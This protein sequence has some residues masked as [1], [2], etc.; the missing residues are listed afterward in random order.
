MK[1]LLLTVIALVN[2]KMAFSQKPNNKIAKGQFPSSSVFNQSSAPEFIKGKVVFINEQGNYEFDSGRLLNVETDNNTGEVHYRTQQLI[3]GFVVENA[4][5]LQHVLNN[6]VVTANGRWLKHYPAK[7]LSKPAIPVNAAL[8]NALQKCGASVYKW[9][10][11][12]E[13][14]LLKKELKNEGATYYPTAV[15]VYYSGEEDVDS[16]KLRLAY[17]FDIYA[18]TPLSRQYIFIDASDGKVL[19]TRNLLHRVNTPA[20]AITVFSGS[21]GIVTD[22]TDG[23][24]RLRETGRGQGIETYNLVTSDNYSAA[25][26]FLNPTTIWNNV[27]DKKDQYATD[28][29]W[30]T[31]KTWDYFYYKF[32]RNSIDNAGFAL[33]SYV[34]YST[35]FY[36][37][38]W[39]GL[40]MTYGDGNSINNYQPLTTLDV[41]GHEISHGVTQYT[42][43]LI[44]SGES[45]AINEGLS[46]IFG[47]A[48]ENYARPLKW[49]WIIGGDFA[50]FRNMSDPGAYLQPDTYKGR[51]WDPGEEV[52]TN[53]GVL[54][55]WFY[56]LSAG[57]SGNNDIFCNYKVQG[58]GIEKAA[59]IAFKTNTQYL[60]PT[61]KYEDAAK[62]SLMAAADLYGE[63]SN[64]VAQTA[65]A[66]AAVGINIQATIPLVVAAAPVICAGNSTRLSIIGGKLNGAAYW[67]WYTGKCGGN[68]AGTGTSTDVMPDS[69]TTYYVRGEGGC[70][71]FTDCAPVTVTVNRVTPKPVIAVSGPTSF[72]QGQSVILSGAPGFTSYLW[73]DGS[74]SV[75]LMVNKSGSYRLKVSSA[76]GCESQLSDPVIVN[77]SASATVPVITV[78]GSTTTCLSG[79]VMLTAS[80]AFSYLWSTGEKLQSISVSKPGSYSVTTTTETGCSATSLPGV[81]QFTDNQAPVP[82]IANLP[83]ITADCS[84]TITNIPVAM[85]SCAGLIHATTNDP[86]SYNTLGYHT[87]KW[88]YNDGNGNSSFQQQQVLI[89]D[90][91]PPVIVCPAFPGGCSATSGIYPVPVA[92]ATDNCGVDMSGFSFTVSGAT[93]RSGSGADASGFF[94]IGVNTLTYT[95]KD[96]NGNTGSCSTTILISAGINA[97]IPDV[98]AVSPGGQANTLYIGY[99]A[100]SFQLAASATGGSGIYTYNWSTGE[101]TKS[102][103]VTPTTPGTYSYSVTVTDS[104]GCFVVIS[105]TIHVVD[106]RCGNKND[107]VAICMVPPGNTEKSKTNCVSPNGAAAQ[108][109]NNSYLGACSLSSAMQVLV[110]DNQN[111]LQSGD[112]T[113][114]AT[115]WPNPSY[116]NFNLQFKSSNDATV[117]VKI[118]DVLGR[119][120]SVMPNVIANKIYEAGGNL[121]PG[122]YIVQA[123]QGYNQVI[124]KVVKQ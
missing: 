84:V 83:L 34:H 11:P 116:T 63:A 118:T 121:K 96:V 40:R 8:R 61:A 119:I 104:K 38:Y 2:F 18:Q 21:Q 1:F 99:G 5:Y 31:E 76:S 51:Y 75:S 98:Y 47:T 60:F 17:K 102:I 46:D 117:S 36:N 14:A 62:Y 44:Y 16:S 48:I 41:C 55:Y 72:C 70:A 24:Y 78:T 69:T 27:N 97:T 66:W 89:K 13:E 7:L 33:R 90:N 58:I 23:A 85:D 111:G 71:N 74:N 115:A 3:N 9:Q 28:A 20:T 86:L 73:S 12:L 79:N 91:T 42:S 30:G 107:K 4:V 19:G 80:N 56:L 103:A 109:S 10:L 26:D 29:H 52:H 59:A 32:G 82:L 77:V 25:V 67:Q 65:S 87:I 114:R 35:N 88:L 50:G 101:H 120:V 54:N 6:K 110:V 43:G 94:A 106:V 113:F 37:A 124:I 81:I 45:G 112:D 93:K 39:D 122:V 92:K 15:L 22:E 64:E 68:L 105:K 53:S 95:V 57:G 123:I 108:L 49:D 100:S